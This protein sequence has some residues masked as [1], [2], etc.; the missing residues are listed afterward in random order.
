M[1]TK[2][3]VFLRVNILQEPLLFML[4]QSRLSLGPLKR[5]IFELILYCPHHPRRLPYQLL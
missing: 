3:K 5:F 2:D 4:F 1:W